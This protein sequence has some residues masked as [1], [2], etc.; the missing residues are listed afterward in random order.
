MR[1]GITLISELKHLN[2]ASTKQENAAQQHDPDRT[3]IELKL[4]L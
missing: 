3:S 4:C 1:G 2:S